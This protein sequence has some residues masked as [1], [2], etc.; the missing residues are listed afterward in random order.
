MS[1][2]D[3]D[4]VAAAALPL[5]TLADEIDDPV[6]ARAARA[7]LDEV[8]DE[9]PGATEAPA[10]ETAPVPIEDVLRPLLPAV[11]LEDDYQRLLDEALT[12]DEELGGA[13]DA[14]GPLDTNDLRFLDQH[15]SLDDLLELDPTLAPGG[16]PWW[17]QN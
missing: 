3:L 1:E 5:E 16:L 10:V 17:L 7:A 6:L 15:L 13:D 11:D 9:A 4:A 14:V 12:R 8:L 2:D